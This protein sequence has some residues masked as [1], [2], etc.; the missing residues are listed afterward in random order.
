VE[1]EEAE[2]E[3]IST[4]VLVVAPADIVHPFPVNLPVEVLRQK[5]LCL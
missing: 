3:V 5:L 2:V 1:A 4:A